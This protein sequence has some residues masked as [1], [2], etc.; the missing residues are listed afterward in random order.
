MSQ[1]ALVN[2]G[3]GGLLNG[4]PSGASYLAFLPGERAMAT[5]P[6]EG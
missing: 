4:V 3:G 1:K 2:H 5:L 6:R